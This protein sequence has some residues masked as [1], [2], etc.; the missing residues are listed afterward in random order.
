MRDV[1]GPDYDADWS[2]ELPGGPRF[3][4]RIKTV[5]GEEGEALAMEQARAVR[6]LLLWVRS[7]RRTNGDGSEKSQEGEA[8]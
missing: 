3:T 2:Y 6:E 7:Q 5:S 8:T 1:S 4:F